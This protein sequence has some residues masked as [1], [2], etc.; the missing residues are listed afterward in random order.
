M[1]HLIALVHVDDGLGGVADDQHRHHARQ[2]GGHRLLA[3][4]TVQ[5]STVQYSTVQYSTVQYSTVHC[6]TVV[7]GVALDN[8]LTLS[9]S[10]RRSKV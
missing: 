4:P 9:L 3:T 6:S 2:Q 8:N 10:V 1:F 5:Y 7:N